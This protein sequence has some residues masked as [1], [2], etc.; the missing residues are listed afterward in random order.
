MSWSSVLHARRDS[1]PSTTWALAPLSVGLWLAAAALTL[2]PTVYQKPDVMHHPLWWAPF[3]LMAASALLLVT[4][5]AAAAVARKDGRLAVASA[6]CLAGL[7]LACRTL[8]PID[9]HAAWL[10]S[11]DVV[12]DSKATCIL[13]FL[14]AL[15]LGRRGLLRAP[16]V[17]RCPEPARDAMRAASTRAL[18]VAAAC[19]CLLLLLPRLLPTQ[20]PGFTYG[21]WMLAIGSGSA[22]FAV[23][24]ALTALALDR[25]RTALA[26]ARV[27]SEWPWPDHP[28]DALG[29]GAPV[30]DASER[31]VRREA[32]RR[33]RHR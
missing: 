21:R 20:Y 17:A 33:R 30:V 9:E 28:L 10:T 5:I 32:P 4:S 23:P 2:N 11:A 18:A 14:A 29:A 16:D 26:D 7:P 3:V 25:V 1:P 8:T 24:F 22:L 6:L 19:G 27:A 15:A 31:F 13:L 12:L